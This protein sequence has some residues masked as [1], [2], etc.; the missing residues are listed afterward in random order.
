MV[1]SGVAAPDPQNRGLRALT[2]MVMLPRDGSARPHVF[3]EEMRLMRRDEDEDA[4]DTPRSPSPGASAQQAFLVLGI[5]ALGFG[6]GFAMIQINFWVG[7]GLMTLFLPLFWWLISR[8]FTEQEWIKRLI[9]LV[10]SI[11]IFV[12]ILWAVWV[13]ASVHFAFGNER[14]DHPPGSEINCIKW[15]DD[16]SQLTVLL[17]NYG[18]ADC[19]I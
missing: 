10:G 11:A 8:A 13:P 9:G 19:V 3:S 6:L 16:Y 5:P 2:R 1:G 12:V 17:Y 14:V 7:I 15:R 4:K 18:S